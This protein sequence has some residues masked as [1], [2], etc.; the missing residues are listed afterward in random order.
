MLGLLVELG[1]GCHLHH[2][3]Q[4]HDG[5]PVRY[6]FDHRQVVSDE[7]VGQAELLLQ[8][9]EQVHDLG[10]DRHVE[11]RD[12]LVADDQR[13][14]DREGAGDA[15]ALALT[16]AE[17]VRVAVAVAA[18][19]PDRLQQLVDA[20]GSRLARRREAV[21]VERLGDDLAHR[22]AGVEGGVGILEDHRHLSPLAPHVTGRQLPQVPT[23]EQDPAGGRLDQANDGP[24]QR[25][26][27]APGLADQ[28]QGLAGPDR[29]V[30]AVHGVYVG[31]R[32]LHDAGPDREPGLHPLQLEE[33]LV[34]GGRRRRLGRHLRAHAVA[35]CA[36]AVRSTPS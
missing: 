15:D 23:L 28:T 21:D 30:D 4:V 6:V 32:A 35:P 3:A 29:E 13:R 8:A 36:A 20:L 34:L 27:A 17:L 19:E 31:D 5:D 25:G 9:F 1:R 22:L 10:L 18:R 24:S 12:R 2:L 33:G 11:G 26:L 16:A 7:E 14:V